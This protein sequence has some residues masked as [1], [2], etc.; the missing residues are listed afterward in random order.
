MARKARHADLQRNIIDFCRLLREREMLVRAALGAGTWRL[1]RLLLAEN[2]GLALLGGALGVLVAFAGLKMLVAFA[3]ERR[4]QQVVVEFELAA[5]GGRDLGGDGRWEGAH[6]ATP[7]VA[8]DCGVITP[9]RLLG[10]AAA[11]R[12]SPSANL[13]PATTDAARPP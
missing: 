9:A 8:G 3:V 6:A 12:V 1:R 7:S 10:R 2:L 13:A 11:M 4:Q 5:P